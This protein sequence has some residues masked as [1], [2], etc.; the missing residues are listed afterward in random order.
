MIY[1]NYLR[2][3]KNHFGL[4]TLLEGEGEGLAFI[5]NFIYPKYLMLEVRRTTCLTCEHLIIFKASSST[6]T[7]RKMECVGH[8]HTDGM[9]AIDQHHHHKRLTFP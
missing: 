9:S 2:S 4:N 7:D 3:K 1:A 5:S 8:H 6:T